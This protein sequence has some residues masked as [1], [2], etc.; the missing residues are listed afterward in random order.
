MP[1]VQQAPSLSEPGTAIYFARFTQGADMTDGIFTDLRTHWFGHFGS[2][3][4]GH[5]GDAGI[6]IARYAGGVLTLS[7]DGRVPSPVAPGLDLPHALRLALR[8][9]LVCQH[10]TADDDH[11][12]TVE[13]RQEADPAPNCSFLEEGPVRIGMRVAFDLLDDLG[14][15]HGDGHQDVWLYREGDVHVTWSVHLVD[16]ASHGAVASC[17]IEG[18]GDAQYQQVWLG[19]DEVTAGETLHRGFGQ[20]LSSRCVV[21]TGGPR[22]L[23]LYWLRDEGTPVEL[24]FDHGALPPFYAS[25]WPTG[26]QQWCRGQMGWAKHDTAGVTVERHDSGPCVHMAWREGATEDGVITHA[27]SLVISLTDDEAELARRI[28]AV[29]DPLEP[30]VVGGTF[31]CYTEE[32]GTYEVGQADPGR[33][34]IEFPADALERVVRVRHFRRKTQARHRGGVRAHVD[35]TPVPRQLMSEGELTDDI[36]VP[37]DRSH[38]NDS[39]DDVIVSHRLSEDKPTTLVIERI[40]GIQATYQSEITGVDLQRRSGHRRDLAVW[41]D[42]NAQRPMLEVDLFSGAI[43][44]LTAF[45]QVDPV[46]WEMPM[47]WFLSCGISRL[48]YCNQ[49][50]QFRM[51][52]PGPESLTLYWRMLNANGGA[53]S[54]TWL[55]IPAGHPR[56]R[57][58]VRMRMEILRPWNG[59]NVEFSDIFPYPSRLVE[60]WQH[61]AVLFMDQTTTSMVY[62]LRPDTSTR[63]TVDGDAGANL[64]Y[65]LFSSDGGNVL[66]FMK[67]RQHEQ[68]PFHYSVCGNYIDVHVNLLPGQDPVPAGTVFEVEYVTEVFGDGETTAEQIRS[69]G[70]CSLQAGE[71]VV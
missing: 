12:N 25:R 64:F 33:V 50:Q 28:A 39:V 34:S 71:L 44:R 1:F 18:I 9:R 61:D 47:A 30:Q 8:V 43:H 35:G 11:G 45:D 24:A 21:L 65:G 60:T 19:D 4:T 42:R 36:C 20:E 26:M 59:N 40:A 70:E 67:N 16:P 41:T 27:A 53:Q 51:E 63:S 5:T 52:D 66:A 15:Y 22:P 37:M 54:E 68:L 2:G 3:H 48:H 49:I 6:G 7:A 32:D 23:G 56:P 62:T 13:I 10:T 31:R 17:H 69:I 29:Q 57:L 55:T 14:H 38:R 46:V 58:E